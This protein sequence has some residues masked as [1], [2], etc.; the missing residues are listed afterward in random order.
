MAEDGIDIAAEQ[1][2]ILDDSLGKTSITCG[3]S[4]M[5]SSARW[6]S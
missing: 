3:L 4:A 1:P 5:K 6:A 2:K